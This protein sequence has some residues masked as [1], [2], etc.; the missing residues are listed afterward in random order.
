MSTA[1]TSPDL[2]RETALLETI[3]RLVMAPDAEARLARDPEAWL[4]EGGVS[5]ADARALAAYG[6]NRLLV[7]RRH[8]RKNLRAAIRVEL[9][10]LAARL[11]PAFDASVDAFLDDAG[12]RSR[13]LRDAAFEFL[14]HAAP[15]W[16]ADASLPFWAVD[17]A[18]LE[19]AEFAAKA[20]LDP[21]PD[22]ILKA[23]AMALDR[24]VLFHPS[25]RV[26]RTAYAV[27][28]LDEEEDARDEPAEEPALLFA[29]RDAEGEVS[30]LSLTRFAA[31]FLERLLAGEPLG[32]AVVASA[33]LLGLPLDP[34]LTEVAAGLLDDLSKCG[35]V[36]GGAPS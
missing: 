25:A 4:L 16:R 12:T 3:Q 31:A 34:A 21:D 24:P 33:T 32:P 27:H 26:L 35:A 10:R 6:A 11:G 7:Y 8:V 2:A 30:W 29:Y 23:G 36:L 15:H 13:Y 19:L 14:E 17:L 1:G 20:A 5:P 9:P 22:T 28:L 18:R